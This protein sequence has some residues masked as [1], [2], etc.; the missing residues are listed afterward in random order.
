MK[1]IFATTQDYNAYIITDG[2][3]GWLIPDFDDFGTIEDAKT[4][5]ITGIEGAET[6]DDIRAAMGTNI[7]LFDYSESDYETV[8]EIGTL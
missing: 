8:N 5:D 7:D 4:H 1:K 6:W 2:V 3:K